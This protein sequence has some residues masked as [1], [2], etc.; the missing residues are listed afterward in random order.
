MARPA[1]IE[2]EGAV[3]HVAARGN[4]RRTIFTDDVD[5]EHFLAVL[6]PSVEQF[7]VRVYLYCLMTNHFHLVVETPRANLGRFMHRLQ[8]AYTVYFNRR[9]RRCG[10]LMQGRY[11]AWL[12]EQDECMLRLSRYVHL[13]PVF[14]A[15]ARRRP[16]AERTTLLRQYP[17]SSY[18]RYIGRTAEPAF[19]ETGPVLA[20]LGAGRGGRSAAY[21]RFVEAG[22]AD[23]DAAFLEAKSA[24]ALCLGSQAFRTKVQL[25]YQ[26]LVQGRDRPED[27]A[28][29]RRGGRRGAEEV[30]EIVCHRLGVSPDAL[31]CRRRDSFTRAIAARMLCDYAGLTQRQAA[32]VLA[33]GT[34]GAVGKQLDKLARE[35]T[36]DNRL[37]R[38][39]AAIAAACRTERS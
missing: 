13:N 31:R 4:E 11:R 17:W 35:L 39:V 26:D 34:G 14:T 6:V 36:R 7:E 33:I 1:R 37:R 28:F 5:R 30:L 3:Y 2:Y 16:I 19:I 27:I 12:V 10:H 23:I 18:R 24:S 32:K 20:L 21:R 15:A 25:L 9:H 29:H 38:Q 22:I 8:T